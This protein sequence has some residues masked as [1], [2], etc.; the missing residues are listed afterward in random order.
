MQVKRFRGSS[1]QDALNKVRQEL[2]EDAVILKSEIVKDSGT[3]DFLKRDVI[4]V[5]AAIDGPPKSKQTHL[6]SL[7]P[8]QSDG[9]RLGYFTVKPCSS[10]VPKGPSFQNKGRSSI[11]ESK[12]SGILNQNISSIPKSRVP[13]RS[14]KSH[15]KRE[16]EIREMKKKVVGTSLSRRSRDLLEH[17]KLSAQE[18]SLRLLRKE[19]S[20]LRSAVKTI[21]DTLHPINEMSLQ[22]FFDMPSSLVQEMMILMECGIEKH[23]ARNLVEKVASSIP[24]NRVHEKD[25]LREAMVREITKMV[26]T[27]GPIKCKKGETKVVAL[28][29]PTGVG[30]TTTLAKL[31]ANSKFIFNK[32]VSLIS[33]DTYRMSAIEHLNT[34]AGIAHL[35]LSAVYSPAELKASLSAQKDKDLIF[36]D[37]AGR[38]PKDKKHILELKKFMECAN[39]DEIHLVLPA[40]IKN[41]D[42]FEAIRR[43]SVLPI[44]RIVVS[45]VDETNILGSILNIAVEV[46]SPISYITNG[47]TIPDDIELANSQ[48]LARLIFKAA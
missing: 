47:Q 31:A 35:P 38:S 20:E 3:F 24:Y 16:R 22:E 25:L 40:N 48:N 19:M 6:I 37:T 29:G 41:L 11:A 10:T 8:G 2:G 18:K 13:H 14:E 4:E 23:I 43:F 9:G 32:N 42:L 26:K 39:P 46:D 12:F 44:N 34:F 5:V 15:Q 28:V 21:T 27:S 7:N 45:K 33:A 30:K 36:I 17:K 1:L